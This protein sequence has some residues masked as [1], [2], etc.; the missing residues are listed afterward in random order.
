MSPDATSKSHSN[1]D[2]EIKIIIISNTG[3]ESIA[4]PASLIREW[5]S[6]REQIGI[7][8]DNNER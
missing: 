8:S 1:K 5:P 4:E 2:T 3:V 7:E 6:E